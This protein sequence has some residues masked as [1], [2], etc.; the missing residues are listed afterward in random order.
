[1]VTE[2]DSGKSLLTQKEN[3]TTVQAAFEATIPDLTRYFGTK[4]KIG[5]AV[6]SVTDHKSG[7][8]TFTATFNGQP[9][10]G[11]ISCQLADKGAAIA[12][13]YCRTDAPITDWYKLAGQPAPAAQ[14]QPAPAA[15]PQANSPG[16]PITINEAAVDAKVAAAAK[17]LG[18]TAKVY[19]YPDGTGTLIL[20]DGWT[21]QAQSAMDATFIKGPA[22]QA[23]SINS[24]TTIQDPDSP[25]MKMMANNQAMAAKNAAMYKQMGVNYN[26]P[27]PPPKPMILVA[28]FS[29][30]LQ[31]FTDLVPQLNQFNQSKGLPTTHIDQIIAHTDVP[32]PF[33]GG[34]GGLVE[35][36][37]TRTTADGKSAQYHVR[38]FIIMTPI[39]QGALT[40]SYSA[41][42]YNAP[43]A[44][45]G[46]DQP[47]MQAMIDSLKINKQA[48]DQVAQQRMQQIQQQGAQG[49][50]MIKQQGAA[51]AAMMQANHDQ[52]MQQQQQRF[53]TGQAQHQAQEDSYA[54]HNAQ[55]NQDELDKARNKD[56]FVE[57]IQGT[58]T[59]YDTQ[60][61]QST[62]VDLMTAGATVDEMN[63]EALDPNRFV[64][65]P[66][67]DE[68]DPIPAQ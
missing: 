68:Q 22:D 64:Q 3:A 40:W 59:V 47:L 14:A 53:D 28:K 24:G 19:Q 39:Q 18:P 6:E 26:P 44:T 32:S 33:P 21:T 42:G 10:H 2:T 56:N 8:A 25:L 4:P 50:A 60:T 58:R 35:R 66:L 46:H 27:P 11:F 63:Q 20:A 55:F 34:K 16:A 52:F 12:V 41:T 15:P 51:N 54:Q 49:M 61:G 1:V 48:F 31:A 65:V 43:V 45:Y 67:R 7:R 37:V 23:I 62:K 17:I 57:T 5:R 36:L 38:E 29:D 9:I 30:P 13:V